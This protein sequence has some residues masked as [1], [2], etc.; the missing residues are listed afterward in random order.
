MIATSRYGEL[1]PE[2]VNRLQWANKGKREHVVVSNTPNMAYPG[3]QFDVKISRLSADASIVPKSP[4]I[5]FKLEVTTKDKNHGLVPNVGR[6]IVEK[7]SLALGGKDVETLDN[8]NVLDTHADLYMDRHK[9]ENALLQGVQDADGLKARIGSKKTDNT[10]F[11]AEQTAIANTLGNRFSIPLDFAIFDAILH[12]F[13]LSEDIVTRITLA[14]ANKVVLATGDA[15][16]TYKISDICLEFDK[17]IDIELASNIRQNYELGY[18]IPFDKI[19]R[20]HYERLSKKDTIWKLKID[21]ITAASLRGILVLFVDD[22]NDRKPFA[23]TNKFYNPTIQRVLVTI[24]GDPHQL[25]A[26]GVLPK[27]YYFEAKKYFDNPNS[28]VSWSD[29]LTTKFGLWV[30]MRSSVDNALHGSGRTVD[31]SGVLLQIDKVAEASGDLTC[32]VFAIADTVLHIK[33]N[34][35]LNLES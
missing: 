30:D 16:A 4:H 6:C 7:K 26:G 32:H 34:R 29:F 25:Y 2:R 3:Q 24:N 12:P 31:K 13:S 14:D 23:C 9:L 1:N 21:S 28:S 5:T 8:A 18:D 15:D 22:S 11:S 20:I 17:V 10:A 33:N 19:T 27:D 35:F